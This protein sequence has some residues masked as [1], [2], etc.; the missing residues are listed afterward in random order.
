MCLIFFSVTTIE[1]LFLICLKYTKLKLT[2]VCT[3]YTTSRLMSSFFQRKRCQ[4]QGRWRFNTTIVLSFEIFTQLYHMLCIYISIQF[5]VTFIYRI[6]LIYLL[7]SAGF[8]CSQ[9]K[10]KELKYAKYIHISCYYLPYYYTRHEHVG[11]FKLPSIKK[12]TKNQCIL[13]RRELKLL[14]LHFSPVK[15]WEG[16]L[17]VISLKFWSESM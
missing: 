16:I 6:F 2:F 1:L 8:P 12:Y 11:V 9:K 15:S 14:K 17:D 5:K 7:F 13:E 10:I 4:R 3:V